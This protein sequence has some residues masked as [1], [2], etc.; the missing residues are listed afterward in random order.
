MSG[1]FGPVTAST[2]LTFWD[3]LGILRRRWR[4]FALAVVLIPAL[5]GAWRWQSAENF[6]A[7]ATVLVTASAAQQ[8]LDSGSTNSAA[9]NRALTMR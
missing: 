4:V 1:T 9:L 5:A 8:A 7:E 3:Y 2:R 6:E